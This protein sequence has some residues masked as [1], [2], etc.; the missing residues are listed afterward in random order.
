MFHPFH[1]APDALALFFVF[2]CLCCLFCGCLCLLFCVSFLRWAS[3]LLISS[4]KDGPR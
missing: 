3:G 1:P 2:V 4:N